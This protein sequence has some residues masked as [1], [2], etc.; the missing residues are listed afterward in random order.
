MR[1]HRSETE[2]QK[3]YRRRILRRKVCLYAVLILSAICVLL[4]SG[5]IF[6]N[7]N[8]ER[9]KPQIK[10]AVVQVARL[11]PQL[12]QN[13]EML[14]S[15]YG[16]M[17]ESWKK[18]LD[19]E[20]DQGKAYLAEWDKEFEQVVDDTLSWMNRVTKLR[21]GRDGFVVVIS[22]DESRILAHPEER[23]VGDKLSLQETI[24]DDDVISIKSIR[25]TTK[26][27]DLDIKFSLITPR[28]LE[29]TKG[30][31]FSNLLE[32]FRLSV[33]GSVIEYR[34]TYIVCGI[35]MM[36][37]LTYI[38]ENAL[39]FCFCYVMLLW[40]LIKWICLAMDSRRESAKTLRLKLFSY[41][42]IV[43]AVLFGVSFYSQ[44]LSDVTN[45]L[46][47]MDKHAD[48][49][50][51][52]LNTYDAQREKLNTWMDKFYETQCFIAAKNLEMAATD[53]L[54][55]R[56]MQEFADT[57]NVKYIYLFDQQG[58][59]VITNS[60][61]DHFEISSDPEDPTHEFKA[62]LYGV[63]G[64]ATPP[65]MD[66]RIG[67]YLQYVGISLRNEADLCDG[68]VMIAVDPTLRDNLLSPLTVETALSNLIIG[69]PEYAIAI[70]KD[71]LR[72]EATTGIGFKDDSIENL[73]LTE[74]DLTKDFSGFLKINGTEYYAGVSESSD[75]Y[76]V[77][78]V[79]PT[80]EFGAVLNALRLTLYAMVVSLIIILITLIR[81]PGYPEAD[82]PMAEDEAAEA[83]VEADMA[84][85]GV[86]R[87]LF[88]GFTNLIHVQ[89]KRGFEE[90]WNM[91]RIPK[92]QQTPEQRIRRIVYRLLLLFCLFILLPTLYEGVD[93]TARG[94]ELN[95]LAY[96]ISGNWQKGLNIFALT[97][98]IFLL[99]AMYVAV[100][101]FNR[102][103]YYIARVSDMR[104]ET[105][106]LLFRNATKYVCVVVFIYYG[107]SQF[108]VDTQTLLAS[109]GILSL[110]ISF[111]A[112][113]LV[114]DI[115]A[116]FFTIFEG[117]YKVGDFITVGDWCGTVVEIGLR[118]TKVRLFADTKI[119]NNSSLRDIVNNDGEV[120]RMV[121]EAPIAYEAKLDEVEAILAEELPLLADKIPGLVKP[122]QYEGVENL[123]DSSVTL[124]I[125][126]YVNNGVRYP[127]LRCLKREVKMMFDRRGIEIPF[128]QLVV[129][130]AR[131]EKGTGE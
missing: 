122:P 123:G 112:K 129:H 27:E 53:K 49:A 125:A 92:D 110:M 46:K 13:E 3:R 61:Y 10:R 101:L 120:A 14:R 56:D 19:V 105:V 35:P 31:S 84:A 65:A 29:I 30:Y 115:I 100:I 20:S 52:T 69:L 58:R 82:A 81:Y 88:S 98:C 1:K 66:E 43:C 68:F 74:A 119:F 24:T 2:A 131:E 57:L 118:T 106:C 114:S 34:D 11:L 50:V 128:N 60:N 6:A 38:I 8:S 111:G 109:A 63:T 116:G 64:I 90:R 79:R 15:A 41:A 39:F 47:T 78:I 70:D 117:T 85:E 36:E 44:V 126:I 28:R 107:L 59:V 5:Y 23:Y 7:S 48:V 18:T 103:L 16:Q 25:T 54:T 12:E 37:Q 91:S 77:P 95:N 71:T 32:Y 113:D 124:R 17:T 80:N 75:L 42:A 108:G 26:A 130:D 40:L 102:I 87:G 96:V 21:V 76:L 73:G 22:K 9:V 89:E 86:S 104:V 83:E 127:A 51:E 72:I 45:D 97:S 67:E 4:Q 121:M 93:R 55:R 33:I 94:M 99:C 62:L